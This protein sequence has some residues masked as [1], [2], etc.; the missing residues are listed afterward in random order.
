MIQLAYFRKD[1]GGEYYEEYFWAKC[2]EC[3][4][5]DVE[6]L[7]REDTGEP[8]DNTEEVHCICTKCNTKFSELDNYKEE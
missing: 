5:E 7:D 3:E 2:P 6:E 4:S 1:N 8:W